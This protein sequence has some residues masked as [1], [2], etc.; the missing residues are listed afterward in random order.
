MGCSKCRICGISN[1]CTEYVLKTDTVE[2]HIPE[3]LLHY[4]QEH[5]IEHTMD[6]IISRIVLDDNP[7]R[8]VHFES[9]TADKFN[10]DQY[11]VFKFMS[12]MVNIQY[13]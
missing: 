13:S 11:N 9:S 6:P 10:V 5:N 2:I 12:G 3:G 4:L 1:G 8:N 7:T